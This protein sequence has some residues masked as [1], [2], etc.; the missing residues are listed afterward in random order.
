MGSSAATQP[1]PNKGFQMAGLQRLAVA[2]KVLQSAVPFL[3]ISSDEGKAVMDALKKLGA[4]VPP[5]AVSPAGEQNEMQ[6]M[7]MRAMQQ[8][9]D[10]QKMRQQMA[11]P[12]GGGG[13]GGAPPMA[14]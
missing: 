6:N 14:A 13:G 11:G 1:T 10:A 8:S 4:L 3:E 12:P 9:Q 2:V 5:G 7:Q